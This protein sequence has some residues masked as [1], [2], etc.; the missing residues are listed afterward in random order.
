MATKTKAWDVT[1]HLDTPEAIAAYLD[2]F[3][4]DGDPALMTAA[5]GDA[6]RAKGMTELAKTA[7]VSRESLYKALSADGNPSFSTIVK[8]LRGLGLQLEAHPREQERS[9]EEA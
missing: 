1:E 9:L 3:F 5:I 4:E 8:I 2:A 6:A 7:G